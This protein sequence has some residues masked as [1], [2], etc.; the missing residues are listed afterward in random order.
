MKRRLPCIEQYDPVGG[1]Q[2]GNF[3]QA[4]SHIG[5]VGSALLLQELG[6]SAPEAEADVLA[7]G[8]R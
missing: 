6:A 1:R 4:Y 5:I 8:A 2:L 7:A 3:P